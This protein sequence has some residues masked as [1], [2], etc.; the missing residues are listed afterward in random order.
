MDVGLVTYAEMPEG[1]SDDQL[2]VPALAGHG[3][4]ARF[5]TWDDPAVDWAE[6]AVCVIRS[7]WD[8]LHRRAAFVAWAERVAGL[9]ELW[10]P[11]P[12]I[13]WNTHKGYLRNLAARGVPIVP[14]VWL[15]AGSRADLAGILAE[16]GWRRAV[17]K[18]AV[19][20]DSYGTSIVTGAALAD[21][22]AQLDTLLPDRD[23]MVQPFLAS[24]GSYGERSLLFIAGELTHAVRRSAPA[25]YGPDYADACPPVVPAADEVALA[26]AVLGAVGAP[27]LYARV[28]LLRDDAGAPCLLEL[29][30]VEP[31]LFLGQAPPAVARL[32]AAIAARARG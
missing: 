10:N 7:T 9:T 4:R 14:T 1:S 3:L 31:S 2:L 5:V 29:E 23:I 11:A 22:Q 15:A 24:V 12:M 32:A 25:G 18:P 20:A 21:A 19:S 16:Q 13:R 26:R 8:Y 28:D 30:L 6:P 17:I 27:T